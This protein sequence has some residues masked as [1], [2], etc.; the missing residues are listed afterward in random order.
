MA[1]EMQQPRVASFQDRQSNRSG[2]VTVI[3]DSP[4]NRHWTFLAVLD[5]DEIPVCQQG[6][7]YRAERPDSI[8]M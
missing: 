7:E 6:R 4:E 8:L 3:Q 5:F 1:T 2:I